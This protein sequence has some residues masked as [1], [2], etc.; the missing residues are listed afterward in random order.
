MG[1]IVLTEWSSWE[2]Q[3]YGFL[4]RQ[5]LAPYRHTDDSYCC[6]SIT[7][8]NNAFSHLNIHPSK[9]HILPH[10]LSQKGDSTSGSIS[11]RM[12]ACDRF[13]PTYF[14]V[15]VCMHML[16]HWLFSVCVMWRKEGVWRQNNIKGK[17][18]CRA[19]YEL[20]HIS[21]RRALGAFIFHL[22]CSKIEKSQMNFVQ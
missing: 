1:N 17:K 12:S 6:F 4:W 22:P 21:C 10:R 18:E 19:E 11:N 15:N 7:A 9:T 5:G 8:M 16:V 14:C 3:A 20:R 2:Q 13:F